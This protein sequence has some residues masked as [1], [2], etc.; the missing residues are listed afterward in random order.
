MCIISNMD[1]LRDFSFDSFSYDDRS[2]VFEVFP[3]VF[4]DLRG[5]F[6]ELLKSDGVVSGDCPGWFRSFGWV[7]QVNRSSSSACVVRGCHAQS[8]RFCQGKLVS[9]LT[10]RI[11]DVITDARPDSATFGASKVYVLDPAKQNM[12][13]VP[14]GFLHAFCVPASASSPALF[15]YFCDNVYNKASEVGV[16]PASVLPRVVGSLQAMS[17]EHDAGY[18]DLA[19]LFDAGP[20]YSEKDANAQDYEE[21]MRGVRR[22]YDKYGSTWYRESHDEG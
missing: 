19:S 17:E 11:Y 18:G 14:R 16:A 2:F 8:G 7:K 9:A 15:E 5:F 1:I 13:W 4:G 3:K 10:E 6:C 20:K 21:W 12:L 22:K